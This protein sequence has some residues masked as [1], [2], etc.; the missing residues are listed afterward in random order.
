MLQWNVIS[1]KGKTKCMMKSSDCVI[2]HAGVYSTG[3]AMVG[4]ICD[5]CEA[6]VCHGR[7]CLSTHACMCPLA[8]AECVECERSVWDHGGR[9]FACSFCHDFLCEDDQFEHQASCQVLEAETF[10][11]VSCNRLGQHSC[12][13]CKACFCDD[14]VRSKV[15]KQEKGKKPP[16]PKCGHETQQT[17]DLSMSTRS[18]KF[19]RQ[20]GGEDADGASGYDAYWK[21]LSSSKAGEAGDREDEYDEYEAE[22]D[23]EDDND[24]RGKDS[25]SEATDVFSNLNLGRTYASGYAHYEES[26]D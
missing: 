16:C 11:C 19:G 1:A 26:E 21:N 10:K 25:D 14:H 13:R 24:E 5:F 2:K 22:D 20:T 12:L 3:L 7:K 18:L 8:D 17:K 4:A 6:W 9:I 23:D 15:F